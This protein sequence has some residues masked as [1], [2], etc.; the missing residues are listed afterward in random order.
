MITIELTQDEL[1]SLAGLI[2]AGV[3]TLGL[4]SV[5]QAASLLTKLEAA[6]AAANAK[7]E[8]QETE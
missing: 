3:K 5:K 8:P 1:Q 2:D 4:A 7:P 6:V